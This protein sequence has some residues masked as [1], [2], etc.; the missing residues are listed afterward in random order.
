MAR[1]AEYYLEF[2][3]LS[4]AYNSNFPIRAPLQDVGGEVYD[5]RY[6][7]AKC[8]GVTDDILAIEK[9]L[10]AIPDRG[11]TVF[12]PLATTR[13][14]RPIV[15]KQHGVYLK[16]VGFSSLY[17]DQPAQQPGIEGLSV[18]QALPGFST[19][20]TFIQYGELATGKMWTNGGLDGLFLKNSN[21]TTGHG[22]DVL[23]VQHTHIRNCGFDGFTRSMYIDSDQGGGISFTNVE[24]NLAYNQKGE[25]IYLGGGSQENYIR[26]NYLVNSSIYGIA[27]V[28]TGNTIAGNHVQ[29]VNAGSGSQTHKGTAIFNSGS[30]T[31]IIGND[32]LYSDLDGIYTAGNYVT[33]GGGNT[34]RNA[35]KSSGANGS[36]IYVNGSGIGLM[37]DGNN[38]V[39]TQGKMAYG[40]YD[41]TSTAGGAFIGPG[42]AVTGEQ[43]AKYFTANGVLAPNVFLSKVGVGQNSPT[44]ALDV[45]AGTTAAA[46]M[47]MRSGVAPTSPNDGDMWF[48]GT[49]LKM[50][51][52]GVTKTVTLT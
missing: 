13:I 47:R 52:G 48:D 14:S 30:Q 5:I 4:K 8:D 28:G 7:G 22:V 40:V 37:V 43:V 12:F 3:K 20:A 44:A 36:G 31:F 1:L 51:V 11:G 26:F 46:S 17:T 10:V 41:N 24:W 34:I 50:R 25:G 39:D 38:I 45:A 9:V 23:N 29:G 42:N 21:T 35:N 19:T 32:T 15:V 49:N 2:L 27:S 18:I 33:V 16:G 6:A